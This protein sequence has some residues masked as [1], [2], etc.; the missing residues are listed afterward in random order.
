MNSRLL[1]II[2]GSF[3]FTAALCALVAWVL[4]ASDKAAREGSARFAAALVAGDAH[5]APN[6]SFRY[7][8]GVRSHFGEITSARVIDTRNHRTGHGDDARTYHLSD[9]LIQTPEG[10]A[11]I[12]LEFDGFGPVSDDITDVYELAPRDVPRAALSDAELAALAKA[13]DRRGG[14]PAGDLTFAGR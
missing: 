1:A 10:P 8:R 14:Y 12:E 6:G 5:A 2:A 13:Y 7:L 4:L 3:V 9:V 11:V